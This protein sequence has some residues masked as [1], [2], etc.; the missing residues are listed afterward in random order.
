MEGIV[1]WIVSMWPTGWAFLSAVV[2]GAVT[3]LVLLAATGL[4]AYAV[5][6]W[7]GRRKV[8]PVKLGV[9][10]VSEAAAGR[11]RPRFLIATFSGYTGKPKSMSGEAFAAALEAGDLQ[12]LPLDESSPGIGTTIKLLQTYPEVERLYLLTTRSEEGISSIDSVPLLRAWARREGLRVEI[13]AKPGHCIDMEDDDQVTR[14]AFDAVEA[15]FAEI[16]KAQG[17]RK[18]RVVVDLTGGVRSMLIGA[19]LACLRPDQ[20]VH[21]IGTRYNEH[22]SPIPAGSFPLLIEFRP[23]LTWR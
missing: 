22:G 16:D 8:H 7:R 5:A 10:K 14:E 6:R 12:R 20:D 18:A 4:L 17:A 13:L 19:L 23:K 9:R 2:E 21:L 15:V 1:E 11:M 3:D